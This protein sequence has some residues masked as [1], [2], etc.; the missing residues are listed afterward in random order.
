MRKKSKR[1]KNN[2]IESREGVTYQTDV[3]LRQDNNTM[4]NATLNDLKSSVTKEEHQ[5]YASELHYLE[6]TNTYHTNI[7]NTNCTFIVFDIETTGLQRDSEI[8]IACTTKCGSK[9]MN[10]YMIPDQKPIA[11][12]A[13]AIHGIS[14]QYKKEKGK[15]LMKE[16]K[17]LDAVSQKTGLIEFLQFITSV[18]QTGSNVVLIAHNGN[19]F[20]FKVLLNALERNTLLHDFLAQD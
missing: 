4:T 5:S 11:Q 3:G 8:Q 19:N 7:D 12:S 14:I 2:A 9:Q 15:V 18:K 17:V 16:G 6:E 1:R 10:K 20:D 13:S